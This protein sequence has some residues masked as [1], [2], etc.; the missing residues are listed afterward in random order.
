MYLLTEEIMRLWEETKPWRKGSTLREDAPNN[1]KQ[2]AEKIKA[3][4]KQEE[5]KQ[6]ALMFK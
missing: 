4:A 5:Q 1:I 3:L 6:I 2:K